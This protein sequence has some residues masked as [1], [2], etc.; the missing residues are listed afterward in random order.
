MPRVP[1]SETLAALV[2]DLDA[3]LRRL[4]GTSTIATASTS[5][6]TTRW[7]DTASPALDQIVI[8]QQSDGT[9]A[10][11]VGTGGNQLKIVATGPNAGQILGLV[12]SSIAGNL[13][14]GGSLTV[15]GAT[16]ANGG[17][18]VSGGVA[19]ASAGLSAPDHNGSTNVPTVN[20]NGTKIFTGTGDPAGAASEGDVWLKG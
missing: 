15:S 14:I 7:K 8:G 1:L 6:G 5:G 13:S 17:L 3:R 12:I 16:N 2:D 18:S 9:Y 4:E 10:I 19:N 11:W 20:V